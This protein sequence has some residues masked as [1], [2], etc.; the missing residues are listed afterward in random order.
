MSGNIL[1]HEKS[2]EDTSE[3]YFEAEQAPK[4]RDKKV[5]NVILFICLV[6]II[7]LKRLIL[8]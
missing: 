6:K 5:I 4:N 7:L 8:H 1:N 2:D 3:T